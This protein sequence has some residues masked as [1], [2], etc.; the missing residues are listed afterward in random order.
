MDAF[1]QILD[2]DEEDNHDFSRGMAYAYFEQAASTFR[3]MDEAL[4]VISVFRTK[5]SY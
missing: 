4:C 2:L 5:S 1:L 3:D